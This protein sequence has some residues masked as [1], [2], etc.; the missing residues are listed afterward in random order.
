ME[1][2]RGVAH[3]RKINLGVAG[4]QGANRKLTYEKPA[5]TM[6]CLLVI[7]FRSELYRE[8]HVPSSPLLQSDYDRRVGEDVFFIKHRTVNQASSIRPH[9]LSIP[10]A[11]GGRRKRVLR[12]DM[13]QPEA[14]TVLS[15]L[16]IRH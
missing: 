14:T 11:I 2:G 6:A 13:R 3:T 16:L 15:E 7:P 4:G 12:S 1:L 10:V 8:W 5:Y 9:F